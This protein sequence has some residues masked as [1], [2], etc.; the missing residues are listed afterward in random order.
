L[1]FVTVWLVSC[2]NRPSPEIDAT[3]KSFDEN[4]AVSIRRVSVVPWPRLRLVTA[5][6]MFG[7]VVALVSNQVVSWES[8]H[9]DIGAELPSVEE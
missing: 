6:S 3:D 1:A 2:E 4:I 9:I 5:L 7:N 8:F